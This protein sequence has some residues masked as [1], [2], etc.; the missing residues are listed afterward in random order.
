MA[1]NLLGHNFSASLE[2]QGEGS[3][4]SQMADDTRLLGSHLATVGVLPPDGTV[5]NIPPMEG[6]ELAHCISFKGLARH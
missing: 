1:Q 5:I 6:S 4:F 2:S 3:F